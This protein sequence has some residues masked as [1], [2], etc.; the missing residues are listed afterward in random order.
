MRSWA[1]GV[2]NIQIIIA[3]LIANLLMIL[4]QASICLL[5]MYIIFQVPIYGDL[6]WILLI[7]GLQGYC[8]MCYGTYT[9]I[10]GV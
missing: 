4:I 3:F 10:H 6:A 2:E 1:A 7:L 5:F 8:G 9:L